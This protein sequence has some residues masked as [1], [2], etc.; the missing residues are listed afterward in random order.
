M[1]PTNVALPIALLGAASGARSMS[2]VAVVAR[3]RAQDEA[4][5]AI[6]RRLDR[7]IASITALLALGEV[8]ADKVPGIPDRI[9][10]GPLLARIGAGA[11]VGASLASTGDEDQGAAAL[12]GAAA[13]FIGAHL[14]YRFRRRLSENM[15]ALAAALIEDAVVA[16]VAGAAAAM[17]AKGSPRTT[18][19]GRG[20]AAATGRPSARAAL[21]AG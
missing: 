20:S 10:I 17:L 12:A 15:P 19:P 1:P 16:A 2:G 9:E 6:G 4:P 14:S 11:I 7:D 21:P 13:A 8:I 3:Q 18:S 5:T